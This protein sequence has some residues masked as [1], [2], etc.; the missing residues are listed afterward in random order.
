MINKPHYKFLGLL[1]LVAAMSD[2]HAALSSATTPIPSSK[3][4]WSCRNLD[5]EITCKAENC[6]VVSAGNFTPMELTLDRSGEL[7][8]CAYSGC[9]S[10]AAETYITVGDYV[11]AIGLNLPWSGIE[12]KSINFSASINQKTKTAVIL[13]DDYAHPMSCSRS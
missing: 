7:S 5:V 11:S 2:C 1:C 10:G 3:E 6:D 4:T 13:T 12:G 8:L 9:W